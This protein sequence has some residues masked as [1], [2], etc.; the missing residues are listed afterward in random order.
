LSDELASEFSLFAGEKTRV[1]LGVA[2]I[3]VS[4]VE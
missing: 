4:D 2:A 3:V 1:P